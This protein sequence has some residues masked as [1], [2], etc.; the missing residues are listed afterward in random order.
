MTRIH[1]HRLFR[2][3]LLFLTFFIVCIIFLLPSGDNTVVGDYFS[4]A[5]QQN[6]L[7]EVPVSD[8]VPAPAP[9]SRPPVHQAS[10]IDSF[11]KLV[12]SIRDARRKE[13]ANSSVKHPYGSKK[14]MFAV[15]AIARN[16]AHLKEFLVRNYMVGVEHFYIYD[17]NHVELEQ[18]LD[19]TPTLEPFVT[20]GLVTKLKWPPQGA[21]EEDLKAFGPVQ[22]AKFMQHCL[23]TFTNDTEW[24][25]RLDTDEHVLVVPPTHE[26]V[27]SQTEAQNQRP[28]LPSSAIPGYPYEV[29]PLLHYVAK[30]PDDVGS[31]L[32]P[33][34]IT[35]PNHSILAKPLALLDAFPNV[36]IPSFRLP[37]PLF[38]SDIV[39]EM[40]DHWVQKRKDGMKE[41]TSKRPGKSQGDPLAGAF[42]VHYYAKSV[43]EYLVKKE[44]S[45][46]GY[47][48]LLNNMYYREYGEQG[49]TCDKLPI[50]Y[51]P[52]YK[53]SFHALFDPLKNIPN[54]GLPASPFHGPK[55]LRYNEHNDYALYQF[56][57]WAVSE[58]LEWDEE[59][60]F[61]LHSNLTNIIAESRSTK[62]PYV[63]GLHH[64]FRNG[65][66]NKNE[67]CWNHVDS[68]GH[69]VDRMCF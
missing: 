36:C 12:D 49:A 2:P 21:K 25:I 38:R 27:L 23:A 51:P 13:L 5:W 47:T 39:I 58:R 60:Y 30:I 6:K 37:K 41:V 31:L 34:M 67:S 46:K 29:W 24:M 26:L 9:F 10:E 43:Q 11:F 35:Y 15:C 65:F 45:L 1:L 28:D 19:I 17:N 52:G 18:D 42:V 64:F 50:H 40:H 14:Y 66:W 62:W 44:Q 61:A 33:W 55:P 7:Q 16:E 32:M 22:K 3:V 8:A 4:V 54:G 48:R 53:E 57:K 63:D 56:L 59:A 68:K 69:R 20:A